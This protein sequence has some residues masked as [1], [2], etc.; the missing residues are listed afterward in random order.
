MARGC[1]R[2]DEVFKWSPAFM[3][4]LPEV[5]AQHQGLVRLI[6]RLGVLHTGGEE[7]SQR[8]ID[9]ARAELLD[10]GQTH[11]RDEERMFIAAGIDPRHAYFHHQEHQSFIDEVQA[12]MTAESGRCGNSVRR[13]LDYLVN[14][15][16]YHILGVDQAMARQLRLIK[17]G[18]S[19]EQAFEIDI[20]HR[21]RMS[22]T[23][24][25]LAALNRLITLVSA[26]NRELAELNRTLEQRV[27]ERTA[28]LAR[29][30]ARLQVLTYE[31]ELTGLPN[32]RHAVSAL[33]ALWLEAKRDRTA[34]SV[35]MLDADRFKGVNDRF[36]HATGDEVLRALGQRLRDAVRTSDIVCRLGGDEFLVICPRS[37]AQGAM[38]VASKILA[39]RQ[40]HVNA[41]GELC[42][43]GAV[44]IG[45]A[46]VQ[47]GM[48]SAEDMLKAADKAL[49]E[50]K[51]KGGDRVG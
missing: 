1:E 39:S 14:W 13:E 34:L 48:N 36:G 29:V 20:E 51:A 37:D 46:E 43:S 17:G 2:M 25:L 35:L 28:E 23:E 7:V 49:Y 10:Y 47:A 31:D 16:A 40:P 21:E 6:N 24:P 22:A 27:S 15:L 50:A 33:E 3:T 30:N 4:E 26:R 9:A 5:D 8:Q 19:G 45:V 32:R 18:L 38:Q 44:S 12:L 41:A 42:W 11:F